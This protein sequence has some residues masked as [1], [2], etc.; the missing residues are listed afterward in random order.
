MLS[1]DDALDDS[2]ELSPDL[3]ATATIFSTVLRVCTE[4]SSPDNQEESTS[5]SAFAPMAIRSN[6]T[7]RVAEKFL[8]VA[9][10]AHGMTPEITF[11][12]AKCFHS[13]VMALLGD[14]PHPP[15]AMRLFDVT[16]FMT[17]PPKSFHELSMAISCLVQVDPFVEPLHIGAFEEDG[18]VLDDAV[19]MLRAKGFS[20]MYLEEALSI[21]N[22]RSR[23]TT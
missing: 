15:L 4:V 23:A 9:L 21:L 16:K 12:G 19:S 22:R 10:D 1:L 14:L 5:V 3:Q 2:G 20:W 7:D 13:D 11:A 18:T 8:E 17:I 6:V